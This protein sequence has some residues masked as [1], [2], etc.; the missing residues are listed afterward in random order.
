[1][2]PAAARVSG[3]LLRDVV[4]ALIRGVYPHPHH[5][6]GRGITEPLVRRQP[7]GGRLGRLAVTAPLPAGTLP[8]GRQPGEPCKVGHR[9]R[10]FIQIPG[11]QHHPDPAIELIEAELAE[12]IML[13]QHGDQPFAVGVLSQPPGTATV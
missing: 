8:L 5:H 10:G 3:I 7:A 13:P 1:M 4:P 6:P 12:R 11:P 2:A 9:R